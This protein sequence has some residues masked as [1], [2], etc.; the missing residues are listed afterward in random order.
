MKYFEVLEDVIIGRKWEWLKPILDKNG[1]E[2]RI[3]REDNTNYAITDD[4]VGDRMNIA[5]ENEMVSEIS[6]G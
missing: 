6:F 2:Y 5:I 4:F 1:C 3:V